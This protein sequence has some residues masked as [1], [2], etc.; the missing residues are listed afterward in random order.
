MQWRGWPPE[1]RPSRCYY[2]DFGN[3]T[4]KGTKKF[5]CAGVPPLGT[6]ACLTLQTGPSWHG[7]PWRIW[8]MLIKPYDTGVWGSAGKKLGLPHPAFQVHSDKDHLGTCDFVLMLRCNHGPVLCR[9]HDTAK[10]CGRKLR[11]FSEH[12]F[13]YCPWWY[14]GSLGIVWRPLSALGLKK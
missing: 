6:R 9:F 7:L 3:S 13:I 8:S 4:S 12:T 5:G 11:F 14:D 1:I 2:S 10:Y